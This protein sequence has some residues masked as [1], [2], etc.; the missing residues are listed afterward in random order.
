LKSQDIF[1]L[2][3]IISLRIQHEEAEA[4][5]STGSMWRDWDSG[6]SLHTDIGPGIPDELFTHAWLG[7]QF[8]VR[9]LSASTGISKSEVSAA[10][11][12]CMAVGLAKP[13]RLTQWPTVNRQ[14]LWEFLV[15]GVRLVFPV[16]AGELTRGIATGVGAPVL[17]QK[18]MTAGDLVPVWPD[19]L[20]RTMGLA[21][22]PLFKTVPQAVKRDPR[23]YAL[24]ALVDAIRLGRPREQK[25]AAGALKQ[26]MNLTP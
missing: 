18:L 21:V 16:Q 19:P 23:L 11:K 25:F 8:S 1:L 17:A 5:A 2:L 14:W 6:D 10:L 13:D 3:K 15:H 22:V 7:Q 4:G 24:L 20:G 26:W 12:R 9:G